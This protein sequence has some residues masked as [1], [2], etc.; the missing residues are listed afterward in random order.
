MMTHAC[1]C[2]VVACF[3][4]FLLSLSLSLFESLRLTVCGG[5]VSTPIEPEKKVI[6]IIIIK[7]IIVGSQSVPL[8]LLS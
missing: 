5:A 6:I 4:F 3:A 2:C 8:H 1:A 7:I